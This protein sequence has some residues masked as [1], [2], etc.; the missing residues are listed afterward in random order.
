MNETKI[1]MAQ[2]LY[3]CSQL[4]SPDQWFNY[5]GPRS[6]YII[7]L[8]L[9]EDNGPISE[10]GDSF[11]RVEGNVLSIRFHLSLQETALV[12]SP[13]SPIAIEPTQPISFTV[14]K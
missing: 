10:Q 6:E 8:T 7:H 3:V 2:W 11:V 14:R 12:W 4:P 1:T 13:S 5:A 9:E